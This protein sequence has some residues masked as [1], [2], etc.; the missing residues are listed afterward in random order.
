M[1][2]DKKIRE[3]VRSSRPVVRDN[4]AFMQ[5]L[6]RQIDLLP[7]PAAMSKSED[8]SGIERL[9]HLKK[10]CSVIRRRNVIVSVIS[11]VF[12]F[13]VCLLVSGL[14]LSFPGS[15]HISPGGRA[16]VLCFFAAAILA[17]ALFS[18]KLLSGK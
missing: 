8:M 6:R 13:A 17:T 1:N 3:V 18:D 7:E 11:G 16:A 4:G 14:V 15:V 9:A 2:V 12:G 10:I 5:E